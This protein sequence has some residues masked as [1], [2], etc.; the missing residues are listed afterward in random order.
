MSRRT[1]PASLATPVAMLNRYW[2]MRLGGIM[3]I[4]S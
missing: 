4:L 1:V 3:K 2:L